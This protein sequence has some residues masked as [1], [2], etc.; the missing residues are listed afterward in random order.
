[1]ESTYGRCLSRL[2]Q[3]ACICASR[4]VTY[5]VT[6]VCHI[7]QVYLETYHH[8]FPAFESAFDQF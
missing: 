6:A 2:S 5:D 8:E 3:F 4:T 7:T 1:M